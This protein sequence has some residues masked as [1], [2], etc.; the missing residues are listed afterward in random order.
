M[1]RLYSTGC[2]AGCASPSGGGCIPSTIANGDSAKTGTRAALAITTSVS[3]QAS[4]L[5]A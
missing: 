5:G 2:R 3:L 4:I 1:L